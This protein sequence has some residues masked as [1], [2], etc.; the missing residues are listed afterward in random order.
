MTTWICDIDGTLAV[1]GDRSPFDWQRVGEDTPNK[2]V[3]HLVESLLLAGDRV[4][5]MSGRMEQCRRQTEIWLCANISGVFIPDGQQLFMRPDEDYRP[6]AVVKRELYEKYVKPD[7]DIVGVIDDR[8]SVVRMWR[9]LG[10]T[11]LQVAEGNF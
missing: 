8:N 2:P 11:C 5:F 7:Y 1:M 3:V 6:D 4:V 9:D 10:L